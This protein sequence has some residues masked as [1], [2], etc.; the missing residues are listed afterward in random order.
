MVT[1]ALPIKFR[2][3]GL[4]YYVNSYY[5]RLL[6]GKN[7]NRNCSRFICKSRYVNYESITGES[8]VREKPGKVRFMLGIQA[9][10]KILEISY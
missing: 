1:T 3:T 2:A 7:K 9:E 10:M 5:C 4:A 6:M 8:A